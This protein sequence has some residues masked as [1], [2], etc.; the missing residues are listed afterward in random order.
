MAQATEL[1]E[2][3]HA[4][5]RSGGRFGPRGRGTRAWPKWPK[6]CP[7]ST[8]PADRSIQRTDGPPRSAG[9][10]R[11]VDAIRANNLV[12]CIGPAGTGKTY[13]AVAMA[14]SDL[15]ADRIRKIVLVRPAVEAGESA[16][17]CRATFRPRSIRYLRPLFD[18]LHEMME[19]DM[20]RRYMEEDLIEVI[21]LAYM[22]GRTLNDA[23][24]ILDEAQLRRSP[25]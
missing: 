12:L 7:A 16:S 6:A 25:R 22:R 11:Y 9:Q 15:K 5:A 10:A 20:I 2:R 19:H 4:Q 8:A 23:F 1:L 17:S 3:L 14:A 21:P 24:I 18:A 13:L